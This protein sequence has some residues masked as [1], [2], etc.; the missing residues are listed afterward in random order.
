MEVK[1]ELW[2]LSANDLGPVL[3]AHL[4]AIL[5]LSILVSLRLNCIIC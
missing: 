1:I 3:E 4:V 5:I 2:L